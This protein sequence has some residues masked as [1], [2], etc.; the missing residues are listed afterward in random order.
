MYNSIYLQ[1]QQIIDGAND[2]IHGGRITSLSS[3]IVL[4]FWKEPIFVLTRLYSSRNVPKGKL[5][6]TEIVAFA[7]QLNKSE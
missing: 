4:P 1:A 6:C 3:Q 2:Y 7:S 5:N